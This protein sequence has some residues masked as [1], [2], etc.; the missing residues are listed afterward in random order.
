MIRSIL[1]MGLAAAAAVAAVL[2]IQS[3]H[4]IAR[5]RALSRM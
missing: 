1:L 3:R 4:E 2:A 5:Y